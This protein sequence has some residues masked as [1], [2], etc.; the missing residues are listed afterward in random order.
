M[1][2]IL[3]RVFMDPTNAFSNYHRA[4]RSSQEEY[5]ELS[6]KCLVI[7]ALVEEVDS[8]LSEKFSISNALN[9]VSNQLQE[10]YK[11]LE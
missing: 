9:I 7:K 11:F 10:V 3:Q 4:T 8:S 1:L 6:N 2:L 5:L